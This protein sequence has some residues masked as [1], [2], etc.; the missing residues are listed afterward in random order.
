M[1]LSLHEFLFVNATAP[2]FM[3]NHLYIPLL[4]FSAKKN[5]YPSMAIYFFSSISGFFCS[6]FGMLSLNTPF[7]YFAWI[8]FCFTSS[9]I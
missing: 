1:K 5:H 4:S 3:Y 2:F 8:S 9:P 7:S 6:V